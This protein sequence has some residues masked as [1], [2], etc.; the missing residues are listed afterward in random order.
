MYN[1]AKAVEWAWLMCYPR[2]S[3][4]TYN[5]GTKFLA[6]F[7]TRIENDYDLICKPITMRNPQS[8]VILK[9]IHK[10]I[11]DIIRTHQLNEI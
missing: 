9:R 7:G 6:E 8:N 1:V 10:T 2:P 3:I 5:K 4:I 11:T